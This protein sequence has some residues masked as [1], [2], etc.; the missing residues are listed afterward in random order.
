MYV[1][2]E[3]IDACNV[4]KIFKVHEWS[5]KSFL[6]L[7][8]WGKIECLQILIKRRILRH[9]QGERKKKGLLERIIWSEA[10][11]RIE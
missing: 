9:L 2:Q 6:W 4:I 5:F 11:F 8:H 3:Q 1:M 10:D 7:N